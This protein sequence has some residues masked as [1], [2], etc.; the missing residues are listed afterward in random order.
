[1]SRRDLRRRV[2]VLEQRVDPKAIAPVVLILPDHLWDAGEDAK[3][4]WI[5]EE[6]KKY[7][8]TRGGFVLVPEWNDA[9]APREGS[10]RAGRRS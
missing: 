7:G 8:P 2:Y 4:A 9:N 3:R 1:M 5:R 10:E 6:V